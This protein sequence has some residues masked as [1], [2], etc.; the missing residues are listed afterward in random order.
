MLV[1]NSYPRIPMKRLPLYIL[2]ASSLFL[3]SCEKDLNQRPSGSLNSEESVTT[4]S[5]LTKAVRGVYSRLNTRYGYS[6][7]IAL[8]GDGHGGDAKIV[9]A[10]YNH[11]TSIH[12]FLSEKTSDISAGAY[13]AFSIVSGRVNDILQYIDVVEKATPAGEKTAVSNQ[14][15]QLYALRG[16]AHLELAR[17]FSYLPTTGVNLDTP[18]SGIPLNNAVRPVGYAYQRSTLRKTYAQI[19]S[20]LTN[21]LE[22]LSKEKTLNS[23]TINYWA[24]EALLARAY[25]YLGD[26]QNAYKYA[27][28]VITSSPYKLYSV[29]DY[30]KVWGQQGTSE[31]LFEVVTTEKDNAGLN[32]LGG[33]TNPGNYPEFGAAD[34]FVKWVQSTRSDDVRAKLIVERS[35]PD[36]G[37]KA[38]YTTKYLGQAGASNPTA[39]NNFKVIRLSELYLIASEALLKGATSSDGKKAVDYYNEL[40]KNRFAN[41]TPATEVTLDNILDERRIEFFCEGHRF[42]DLVRNKRDLTTPYVAGGNGKVEYLDWRTVTELPEREKNI[43]KDLVVRAAK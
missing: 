16:L 29:E 33:Y 36:G 8:Y 37:A 5:D 9:I 42:F 1:S 35:K 23:G 11:S 7:E 4:L 30:T 40:R 31:S 12:R 2:L 41:Y 17:I 18:Y 21:S 6:G 28:D 43:N 32:S 39:M 15:S 27:S 14:V 13:A 38:Y 22:G 20:D 24:A 10:S 26:W 25:L 19:T 34:D 3:T